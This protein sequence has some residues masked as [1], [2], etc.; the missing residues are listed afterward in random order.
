[1]RDY[2][3]GFVFNKGGLTLVE[4]LIAV[5]ILVIVTGSTMLVFRS[6]TNAW[7]SGELKTEKYQQ[8]RLLFDLFSRELSSCVLSKRHPF[9]GHDIEFKGSIRPD[10]SQAEIFF[11]GTIPGRA[12]LVE[13]GYW[14]DGK[15]QMMCHHEEPSDADYLSGE[16]E[17]CATDIYIFDVSFFDGSSWKGSWDARESAGEYGTIPKAIRI[18]LK[19]GS[20]RPEQFET[21]IYLP[22]SGS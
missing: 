13:R 20:E 7:R 22:T 14:V 17:P 10:S 6:V 11:T 15:G 5:A 18:L 16:D 2:G 19:V 21:L 12:G 3:R 9:I 8:A 4:L 1:L